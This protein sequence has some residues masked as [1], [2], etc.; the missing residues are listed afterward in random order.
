[1]TIDEELLHIEHV[2]D[3]LA[4]RYPDL[5]R[6]TVEKVV[7]SAHGH[8]AN[9]RMRDSAPLLVEQNARQEIQGLAPS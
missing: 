9:G 4:A 7:H 1:M 2:I 3:R 8:I 6:E 5:P